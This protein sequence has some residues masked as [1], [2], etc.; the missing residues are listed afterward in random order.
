M[1]ISF[2]KP[3]EEILKLLQYE[4]DIFI[5]GCNACAAKLHVGGEPEVLRMCRLLEEEGKHIAGWV[6]PSAAC[7]VESFGSLI[8][9]NPSI[10]E[11]KSIL[12]MACGSGVS[13]VSRVA[14]LPVYP[15]NNTDSLG[16]RS[17]GEVIPDLCAM[18]GDCVI[19]CFGGIC[20]KGQCPKQL[21]NGPCGGSMSG[22]CEVYDDRDCSWE[23][24]YKKL[25]SVGKLNLL[26]RLWPAQEHKK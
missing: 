19:H 11:A 15:S 14:D 7:S 26:D 20:P 18:C 10:K 25:Q 6:I 5:I 22:K 13:T 23:L 17:Q 12:V 1:I 2:A 24:I 8:E 4:D 3:F 16:G 9:K 21:L